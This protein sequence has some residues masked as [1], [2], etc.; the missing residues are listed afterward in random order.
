MNSGTN[1]AKRAESY[2]NFDDPPEVRALL[3]PPTEI[4]RLPNDEYIHFDQDTINTFTYPS[5]VTRRKYQFD[6]SK[7]CL[8]Y[9]TL[10]CLPTGSGKTLIAA[11]VIDGFQ[12]EKLYLWHQLV[13]S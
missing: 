2:I 11:V 6:I 3:F 9:N 1:G 7:L 8:R 12:K 10:V 4:D 13:P 5:N